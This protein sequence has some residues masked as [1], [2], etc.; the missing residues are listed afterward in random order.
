MAAD[1]ETLVG[2]VRSL[3]NQIASAAAAEKARLGDSGR[4]D[5][6]S[7]SRGVERWVLGGD[8]DLRYPSGPAFQPLPYR[9]TLLGLTL[10]LRASDAAATAVGAAVAYGLG[11]AAGEFFSSRPRARAR[12]VPFGRQCRKCFAPFSYPAHAHIM[13]LLSLSCSTHIGT[14]AI[15]WPPTGRGTDSAYP[16]YR[17]HGGPEAC[18]RAA[19]R[20]FGKRHARTVPRL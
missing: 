4:L 12:L 14:G 1:R 13:L 18:L 19:S 20:L 15:A 17:L 10:S 2:D 7:G 3:T 5:S 16:F 9:P 6:L 11:H 8:L